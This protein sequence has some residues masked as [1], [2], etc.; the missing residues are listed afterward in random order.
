MTTTTTD[1]TAAFREAMKLVPGYSATGRLADSADKVA[2]L[3]A[4]KKAAIQWCFARPN[5]DD[6]RALMAYNVFLSPAGYAEIFGNEQPIPYPFGPLLDIAPNATNAAVFLRQREEALRKI[7]NSD[8][9]AL[10]AIISDQGA[11]L[12]DPLRHALTGLGLVPLTQLWTQLDTQYGLTTITS[13]DI[14]RWYASTELPFDRSLLLSENIF[15]DVTAHNRVKELLGNAHSPTPMQRLLQLNRKATDYHTISAS[16]IRDY[17][18][19]TPVLERTYEAL[20][21]YLLQAETRHDG[22][23]LRNGKA[24]HV[25]PPVETSV[26][27]PAQVLVA[28]PPAPPAAAPAPT[29][30]PQKSLYCFLCGYGR[31]AGWQCHRMNGQ[32]TLKSPFTSAMLQVR[33]P[34]GPDNRLVTLVNSTGAPVQASQYHDRRYQK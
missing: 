1:L 15:N 32:G 21:A 25:E 19:K 24:A 26:D 33:S 23:L 4:L 16:W 22:S 9:A 31:H 17:D 29:L 5:Y 7:V 20:S 14:A 18:Q 10:K 3:S 30:K 6:A 8:V 13:T 34:F 11:Q 28:L 27:A 12:F 2:A